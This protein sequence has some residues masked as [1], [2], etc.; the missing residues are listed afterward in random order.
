VLSSAL[1]D[2]ALARNPA[3]GTALPKLPS[4]EAAYFEPP[5]VERIAGA[6][7]EPCGLLVRIMGTLGPRF[8]EAVALRRRSVHLSRDGC[9]SQSRWAEVSGRLTF[10]PTKTHAVRRVPLTASLAAGLE[11]HLEGVPTDADALLFTSPEG[12]PLRYSIFRSRVWV[13]ALVN[14]GLPLV[15]IHAS[16]TPRRPR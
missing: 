7:P 4:D 6:M 8:G 12:R 2:G 14:P 9:S 3:A 5:V 1:R 11:G 10:G 13:P 15:G 16:G